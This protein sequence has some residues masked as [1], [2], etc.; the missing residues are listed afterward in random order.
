MSRDP[1][2]DQLRGAAIV[3]MVWAN[4]L[5]HV[6][7]V[8]AWSKHA[9]DIGLTWVDL[10]APTFIFAIG[11]TWGASVRGRLAREGQAR[12]FEFVV[13]RSMALVGIGSLFAL[14]EIGYGFS[15]S[16]VPWGTLQAIGVASLLSAPLL[17]ARPAVRL[18]AALLL[19]GAYQ[20][21]LER[22][23][24][25]TVLATSHA[26]LPGTLSWTALLLL[27]TVFGDL[28]QAGSWR[29][30]RGLALGLGAAGLALAAVVPISKHRM[31]VS[32]D[33]VAVGIGAA[34]YL[35]ARANPR[36]V[37]ALVTWGRNPLVLYV[38]HLFALALLLVPPWPAWHSDAPLW[39]ALAQAAGLTALLHA[40]ATAL[41]RRGVTLTL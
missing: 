24:L 38:A 33:L 15:G 31:S 20:W 17:P 27:A 6:R 22:Y 25:A 10:V 2:L 26:G 41:A 40:G 35:L 3:A 21:A 16:A 11:L 37:A 18:V 39:L 13:R 32:F 28:A 19:A 4:A 14:G 12:T 1:A 29:A 5:E 34:L 23:W 9:V 36:P 7:A 8:P 30:Y